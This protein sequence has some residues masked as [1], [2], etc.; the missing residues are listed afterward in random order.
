MTHTPPFKGKTHCYPI[1]IYY[2]DTDT[3]DVVY[4]ANYVK[5]AERGR[6][7][8]LR[9][10][11]IEQYILHQQHDFFFAAYKM[12]VHFQA[13]AHLDELITVE[14]TLTDLK[15]A[16]LTMQQVIKR[17]Q[18]ILVTLDITIACIDSKGRPTRLPKGI[19]ETLT[20]YIMSQ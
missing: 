4:H 9:S 10:C 8:F 13:P 6:S 2:E 20:P 1:R 12:A 5:F 11:G 16:K 17:D 14:T 15:P 18:T 19:A 3:A 7:E